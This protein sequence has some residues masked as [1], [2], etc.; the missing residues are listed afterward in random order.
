MPH[1]LI[2][3]EHDP[4]SRRALALD[5]VLG[6]AV[7]TLFGLLVGL[8][9]SAA[10]SAVAAVATALAGAVLVLR[11]SEHAVR[12]LR[13]SSAGVPRVPGQASA[14]ARAAMVRA[15]VDF[16]IVTDVS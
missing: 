10:V 6:G 1:A 5:V 9:G 16:A 8:S 12:P 2:S 14:R 4:S 7:G 13:A 11:G 15:C 3:P